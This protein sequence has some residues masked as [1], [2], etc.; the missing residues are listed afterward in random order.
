[1]RKA[2][3]RNCKGQIFLEPDITLILVIR[4][5]FS[6]RHL[7]PNYPSP[8][9][10]PLLLLTAYGRSKSKEESENVMKMLCLYF[11]LLSGDRIT[12][13]PLKECPNE[14]PENNILLI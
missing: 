13:K 9:Y 12:E 10:C 14:K 2:G 5:S 6:P 7:F 4:A 1:M 3:Y 11:L 8:I